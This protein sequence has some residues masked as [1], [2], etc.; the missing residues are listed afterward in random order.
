MDLRLTI[1]GH[2]CDFALHP[3][4]ATMAARVRS[5]GQGIYKTNAIEWWRADTDSTCG[6]KYDADTVVK[7]VWND[8]PAPFDASRVAISAVMLRRPS[9]ATSK[10]LCLLG[11]DDA[12]C[13]RTWTWRGV[14]HYDPARFT[15]FAQRWDR[16][17]G[18]A[19]YLV[20]DEIQYDGRFADRVCWGEDRGWGLRRPRVIDLEAVRRERERLE[21]IV[22]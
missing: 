19:D 21:D 2:C 9:T 4:D 17:L 18:V 14:M 20:V 22:A 3:V 8:A 15:F 12:T 11:Y 1:S 6:L 13:S 10:Y 5:L 16:L 7:A